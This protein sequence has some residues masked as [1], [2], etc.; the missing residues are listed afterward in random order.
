MIA[1]ANLNAFVI[2]G[3]VASCPIVRAEAAPE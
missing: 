3:L 2:A 1:A